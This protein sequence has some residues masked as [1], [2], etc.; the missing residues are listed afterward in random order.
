MRR[1]EVPTKGQ[2]DLGCP[3]LARKFHEDDECI[4]PNLGQR[5]KKDALPCFTTGCPR[6]ESDPDPMGVKGIA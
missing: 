6:K 4:H 5:N 2:V 3:F 1:N